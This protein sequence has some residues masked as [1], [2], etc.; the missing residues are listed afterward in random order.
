MKTCGRRLFLTWE[1]QIW[2]RAFFVD[3]FAGKEEWMFQ[4]TKKQIMTLL[5]RKEDNYEAVMG[6]GRRK[7]DNGL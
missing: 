5:V 4:V 3:G 2:N 6:R 1:Y 7:S